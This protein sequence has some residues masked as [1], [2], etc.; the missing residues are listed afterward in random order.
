MSD[1]IIQFS[2]KDI[3]GGKVYEPAWYRVRINDVTAAPSANVEKPSTNITMVAEILFNAENGDQKYAEHPLNNWMFNTRAMGFAKGFFMALGVPEEDITENTRFDF[4]NA[5][6]K[7]IEVY[8]ENE[9]YQ[10]RMV[11]RVNHKYR[12][13]KAV[14]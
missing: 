7:E 6:G 14:A 3:L 8:I 12:A 4:K 13:V 2:K 9:L 5:I 1:T 10:G 11:N